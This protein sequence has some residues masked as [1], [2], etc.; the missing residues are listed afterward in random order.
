MKKIITDKSSLEVSLF[1]FILSNVLLLLRF[2]FTLSTDYWFLGWNLFL[3]AIPCAAAYGIR[4][5]HLENKFTAKLFILLFIWFIFYPN[6]PYIF[7]DFRHVG[8]VNQ[9]PLWVDYALTALF[10]LT[11]A[12]FG[13][14]SIIL[15]RSILYKITGFKAG[16]MV[17][18]L[19]L[20]AGFGVYLG[21]VL[22]FNSW[23]VLFNPLVLIASLFLIFTNS[24]DLIQ[25]SVF[26]VAYAAF[27]QILFGIYFLF[28]KFE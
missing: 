27:T 15:I 2:A 18:I 1:L 4:Y 9:L 14:E 6:S 19:N 8:Y 25:A 20:L 10:S 28:R 21:L 16:L 26:T 5:L 22:R 7:V 11:G 24:S 23:D 3:A 13:F 17:L 12:Y